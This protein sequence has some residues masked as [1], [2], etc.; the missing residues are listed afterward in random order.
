MITVDAI[1]AKLLK[2]RAYRAFAYWHIK[3]M[4]KRR[5]VWYATVAAKG[6]GFAWRGL[7]EHIRGASAR[8]T[9]LDEFTDDWEMNGPASVTVTLTG[10]PRSAKILG[11]YSND[12]T[13]KV[14]MAV[15]YTDTGERVL[16]E[17]VSVLDDGGAQE[18]DTVSVTTRIIAAQMGEI[19]GQSDKTG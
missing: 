14:D 4:G 6:L 19:D 10:E 16:F 15:Q 7:P 18:G 5:G 2:N 12:A 9:M 11:T 1:V 17:G 13:G 3:R 8:L